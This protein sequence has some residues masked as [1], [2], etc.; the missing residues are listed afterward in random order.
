MLSLAELSLSHVQQW[1]RWSGRDRGAEEG[2]SAP[3]DRVQ[4]HYDTVAE[5][6]A[7]ALSLWLISIVTDHYE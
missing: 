2:V 7:N 4:P 3:K 6:G 5:C 1:V